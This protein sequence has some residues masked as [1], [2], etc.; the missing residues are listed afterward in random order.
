VA[1]AIAPYEAARVHGRWL[2]RASLA[3]TRARLAEAPLAERRTIPGLQPDR[4]DVIVAGA[5]LLEAALDHLG[6]KGLRVSD[7]GLRWGL[8]AARFGDTPQ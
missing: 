6:A 1:N 5:V 4:A 8:L 3:Q 2:S 7:H